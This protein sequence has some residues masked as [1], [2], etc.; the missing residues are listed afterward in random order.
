MVIVDEV[1]TSGTET[2][3]IAHFVDLVERL[4]GIFVMR[5]QIVPNQ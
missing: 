1:V 3:Q 4:V 2:C 5:F